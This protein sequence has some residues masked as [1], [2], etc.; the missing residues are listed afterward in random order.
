[1]STIS[2][3]SLHEALAERQDNPHEY[4]IQNMKES[5]ENNSNLSFDEWC[6]KNPDLFNEWYESGLYYNYRLFK[7]WKSTD[8]N[9]EDFS[10]YIDSTLT[11]E[12]YYSWKETDLSLWTYKDYLVYK[13]RFSSEVSIASAEKFSTSQNTLYFSA[14]TTFFILGAVLFCFFSLYFKR[15][16]CLIVKLFKNKRSSMRHIERQYKKL[17]K[18]ES[19]HQRGI[20]SDEEYEAIKTKIKSKIKL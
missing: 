3:I 4:K 1:M 18:M 9:I 20:I 5:F 12:Q 11:L 15:L 7:K 2:S 10:E 19:Y 8:L 13:D 6:E 16:I 17:D 14:Y